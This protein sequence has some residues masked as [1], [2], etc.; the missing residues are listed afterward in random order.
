[1]GVAIGS[2]DRV[3]IQRAWTRRELLAALG[4][5]FTTGL[6]A[7]VPDMIHRHRG[8]SN[9]RSS[10]D[11]HGWVNRFFFHFDNEEYGKAFLVGLKI[12]EVY[13]RGDPTE[14]CRW[15]NNM[16]CVAVWNGQFGRAHD[17]LSRASGKSG[18]GTWW[19]SIVNSN[20]AYVR[21]H[22]GWR[23]DGLVHH[24]EQAVLNLQSPRAPN[25]KEPWLQ[26]W[27]RS[28][29]QQTATQHT[30]VPPF[31][32]LTRLYSKEGRYREAFESGEK[33]IE[34]Q[35]D[36]AQG[37]RIILGLIAHPACEERAAIKHV[38]EVDQTFNPSSS[39]VHM[40]ALRDVIL[41]DLK[42]ASPTDDYSFSGQVSS[43]KAVYYSWTT[44]TDLKY[45]LAADGSRHLRYEFGRRVLGSYETSEHSGL[46]SVRLIRRLLRT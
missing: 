13:Q 26:L 25:P 5:V 9:V 4:L 12:T 10:Q 30:L 11:V 15:L 8:N 37:S 24:V 28:T 32:V 43:V 16:A 1:M 18:L 20:L 35:G 31:A 6:A 21:Y 39:S 34:L 45:L 17:F 29:P 33:D 22:L 7:T 2:A 23:T 14:Y 19:L 40:M 42:G 41:A 36:A 27:S 44:F 3:E 38:Q 46:E